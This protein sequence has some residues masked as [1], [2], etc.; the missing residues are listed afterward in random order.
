MRSILIARKMKLFFR[1]IAFA[2]ALCGLVRATNGANFT[3]TA[4]QAANT[5]WTAAIWKTNG[6]TAVSPV[7]GNTYAE[8]ANGVNIG[9]SLN[10]TRIRN[11]TANPPTTYAFPGDSLTMNTNTELRA[12]QSGITLNFRGT[13]GNP[14]LVL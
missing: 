1:S 6:G 9:N 12:K 4:T 8:V 5:D 11:P 7:A 3:T 10:S 13:N 14:G 2:L